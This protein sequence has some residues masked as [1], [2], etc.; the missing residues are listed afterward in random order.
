LPSV[1]LISFTLKNVSNNI[2]CASRIFK[3]RI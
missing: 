2:L 1:A 3:V